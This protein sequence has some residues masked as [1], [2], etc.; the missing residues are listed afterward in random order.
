MGSMHPPAAQTSGAGDFQSELVSLMPRLRAFSR[1]LCRRH[2]LADDLVQE[3]LMKAWRG[4]ASFRT[5][6]N[7]KAWLFTIM[8]NCY[9]S[10]GRRAGREVCW[11]SEAGEQIAGPENAQEM[12]LELSRHALRPAGA[13]APSSR[14]RHSGG[15]RRTFLFGCGKALRHADRH[16][17]EPRRSWTECVVDRVPGSEDIRNRRPARSIPL[18]S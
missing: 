10:L 17:E 12:A 1:S 6:T 5:D 2:D 15:R 11:D 14:V 7:L 13:H 4:R 18:M 16:H 8:R 9:Y 3:T